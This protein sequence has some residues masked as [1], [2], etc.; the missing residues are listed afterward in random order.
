VLFDDPLSCGYTVSYF[1]EEADRYVAVVRLR[2][3]TPTPDLS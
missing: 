3:S 1:V 2:R